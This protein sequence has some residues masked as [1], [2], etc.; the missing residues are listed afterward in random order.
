M[1]VRPRVCLVTTNPL[2]V[3]TCLS[4]PLQLCL[5]LC[6]AF[7]GQVWDRSNGSDT[8]LGTARVPI[9]ENLSKGDENG[10]R[11]LVGTGDQVRHAVIVLLIVCLRYEGGGGGGGIWFCMQHTDMA[12]DLVL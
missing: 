6:Y 3:F 5:C 10:W 9:T 8:L 4:L 2:W 7:L 1:P 12:W 11:R